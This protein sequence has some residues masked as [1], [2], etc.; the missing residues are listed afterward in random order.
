MHGAAR[1]AAAPGLVAS[2]AELA[3][4]AAVLGT[5]T[6]Q[7]FAFVAHAMRAVELSRAGTLFRARQRARLK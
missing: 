1:S 4:S 5:A 6:V 2:L 7:A 3:Q